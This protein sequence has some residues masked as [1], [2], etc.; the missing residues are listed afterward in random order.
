MPKKPAPQLD[1]SQFNEPY[2]TYQLHLD[3]PRNVRFYQWRGLPAKVY[4]HDTRAAAEAEAIRLQG[5]N[6][7]CSISVF[8]INIEPVMVLDSTMGVKQNGD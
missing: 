8:K 1:L 3:G 4:G 7:G 2:E 5:E 6:L